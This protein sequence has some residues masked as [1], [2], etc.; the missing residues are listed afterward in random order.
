MPLQP[1]LRSHP[2]GAA[3]MAIEAGVPIVPLFGA[4]GSGLDRPKAVSA[5]R[6]PVTI[7]VGEWIELTL[8]TAELNGLLHPRMQHL[9]ERA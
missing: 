2:D 8:P 1:R 7:V 9:L 6:V 3:R 4:Y 5:R